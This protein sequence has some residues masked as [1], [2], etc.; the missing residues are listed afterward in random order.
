M[1]LFGSSS[2]MLEDYLEVCRRADLRV[3][4]VVRL[5]DRQPRLQDR[6]LVVDLETARSRFGE[7]EGLVCAFEPRHRHALVERLRHEGFRFAEALVDVHAVIAG[8]VGLG[9]GTFVNALVAIGSL[10]RLGDHVL[11]NRATSLGHHVRVGDHVSV[12]PGVT[13]SGGVALESGVVVG[14]GATILPGVVVGEGAIVAAG[15]VVRRDVA[16]GHVAFGHP[17]KARRI[18]GRMF[19]KGL[20]EA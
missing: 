15:A 14:A 10:S 12:G 2:P 18:R 9:R 11:V 4:A 17:A 13:V 16:P 5:D 19:H 8:S 20:G 1:L 3:D 7:T 6:S